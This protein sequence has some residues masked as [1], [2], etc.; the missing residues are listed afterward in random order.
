M[1]R[2]DEAGMKAMRSF[3][4]SLDGLDA[5]YAKLEAAVGRFGVSAGPSKRTRKREDH[6]GVARV[7]RRLCTLAVKS[8]AKITMSGVRQDMQSV[9]MD[10]TL[11]SWTTRSRASAQHALNSTQLI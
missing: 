5:E 3:V 9:A 4:K 6:P 1:K 10:T 2:K 8:R 11:S 7:E